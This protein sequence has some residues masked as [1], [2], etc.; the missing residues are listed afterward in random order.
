MPLVAVHAALMQT[1][2]ILFFDAWEIPGTP[3]ARLWDPATNIYTAVPN[4]FAE[5][6]CAGHVLTPDGRLLTV[7]GHN[8]AGVG[9]TDATYFDPSHPAVDI[10]GRPELRALVSVGHAAGRR[11]NADG[12]RG[13]Q[14]PE[15]SP[16]FPKRLPQRV[17][18]ERQL[19]GAQKD[20]GEYPQFFQAPNGRVFVSGTR[21][22]V[23]IVAAQRRHR[24]LDVARV[25]GRPPPAPA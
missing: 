4:G 19:P 11:P 23:P 13:D 12:W 3:S 16:K 1:G 2:R 25:R 10:V 20:V 9:T 17:A 6:F 5:L 8:G 18:V 7:G 14:P 21:Q 22:L 15:S 24:N